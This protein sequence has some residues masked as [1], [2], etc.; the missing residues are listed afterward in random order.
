MTQ[1]RERIGNTNTHSSNKSK[2]DAD[3][4]VIATRRKSGNPSVMLTVTSSRHSGAMASSRISKMAR[5]VYAIDFFITLVLLSAATTYILLFDGGEL[6][7]TDGSAISITTTMTRELSFESVATLES[8]QQQQQQQQQDGSKYL[9]DTVKDAFDPVVIPLKEQFERDHE[10][11]PFCH[12]LE[13][14][15]VTFS[16]AIALKEKEMSMVSHHCKHWGFSASISI[17]VWTELSPEE[18]MD[19]LQAFHYN[20]CERGQMTITT[21]SPSDNG[22]DENGWY[23]LNQLRNLAIRGIQTTHAVYVDID[24]WISLDLFTVLHAPST[25]RELATDPQLA[26][27][28][29]AF[30][31]ADTSR[32][33]SRTKCLGKI[34]STYDELVVQLS[35][36]TSRIMN[37]EDGSLQ[38][39]TNYRSW[40]RQKPGTL[41]N[42]D[43]VSSEYYEPYL[44]FRYCEGLPPFQEALGNSGGLDEKHDMNS[45]TEEEIEDS[46]HDLM[47]TWILHLLRLG[48]RLKQIGG[49]F[50]ARLPPIVNN[51]KSKD[52]ASNKGTK[53]ENHAS[54]HIDERVASI[55][56]LRATANGQEPPTNLRHQLNR[57]DFLDWL[58]QTVPDHRT[59][60]R[61]I[62]N[63]VEVN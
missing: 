39:S 32:C 24:M 37:A 14:R 27:V 50:V 22:Y 30:E 17:A 63:N 38:V 54:S 19:K 55:P 51:G 3:K 9:D 33:S 8:Q 35:E 43:C 58:Q 13:T 31:V 18:I 1:S 21:L 26:I 12:P 36:K 11:P 4:R 10:S 48:F 59:V 29:P 60:P 52:D 28:I 25:V 45:M 62:D 5:S 56:R 6:E 2:N 42:I 23:P 40:I 7:L 34:P 44:A 49:G 41:E 20:E 57:T 15:E 16:L 61:C 53:N 47:S 46:R